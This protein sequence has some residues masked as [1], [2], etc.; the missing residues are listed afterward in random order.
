MGEAQIAPTSGVRQQRSLGAPAEAGGL[1]PSALGHA[2]DR[3]DPPVHHRAAEGRRHR[4]EG[5]DVHRD[6]AARRGLDVQ[7][8]R[9]DPGQAA[10]AHRPGEPLRHEAVSRVP[11]RRRQRRRLVH[12]GAARAR[13]R[14]Q[15]AAERVHDRAALPRRRGGAHAGMARH[16]QH[17]REPPLRGG[18]AEGRV[19]QDAEGARA[20]RHDWRPRPAH[21]TRLELDAVAR[22]HRLG[23]GR[24]ASVTP[25]RF[26]TS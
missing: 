19:A 9:H 16:R 2:R 18:R 3:R 21:Q 17:L 26:R 11:V 8:H 13:A 5:T 15:G 14:A 24:R 25:A 4:V 7:R 6:D 10:R 20:A 23:H 12:G 22:R 1:R